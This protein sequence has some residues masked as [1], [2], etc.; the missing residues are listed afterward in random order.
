[1]R[2][3]SL[4]PL[5]L[6]TSLGAQNPARHALDPL[7]AAEIMQTVA[8]LRAA[9]H[10]TPQSRFG[11]ITVQPQPKNMPATRAVGF[12]GASQAGR[13]IPL[14]AELTRRKPR[15]HVIL[16]GPAV[17]TGVE[18]YYSDLTGDGNRAPQVS[19]RA[20]VERLT[21]S[22]SGRQWFDPLPLLSTSRIPTLWLLGARDLS[23]PTFASARTLDSL[24]ATGN[25]SHTVIMY[26]NADHGLRD[27]ETGA[28]VPLFDDMM[29]WMTE[30]GLLSKSG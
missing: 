12:F 24:R 28:P 10:L 1:M 5:L 9:G 13:V 6:S 17:S 18:Q 3:A 15:F 2:L 14:A 30:R 4:V 29:R 8:L 23:V 20:E 25:D 16:S 22:F 27:V 26:P 11:T 7:S 21:L 19:D